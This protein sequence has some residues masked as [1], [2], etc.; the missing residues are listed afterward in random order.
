V[1]R[2][3]LQAC[4]P[5][6][7]SAGMVCQFPHGQ[8]GYPVPSS[9]ASGKI[10]EAFA[11]EVHRFAKASGIPV[12]HLAR[13]GK[14][15]EIARPYI[16]AA[17]AGGKGA[18]ARTG[19]AQEKAVVWRS[20]PARGQRGTA[21][22]HTERGRQTAFASHFYSCLRDAGRGP[23][24]RKASACAPYPVWI[25][26]NGHERARR[27]PARGGTGF[28]ALDN[29]FASCED[30]ALPRR[31]CDRLGPGA[32]TGF[33]WRW[34]HRLPSPFTRDDLRAGYAC[35]LAFRQFGV[36]GTRVLDRPA[37]GRAFFE[38]LIRDHPGPGRPGRVPLVFGRNI[39]LAGAHPAPGTFRTKVITRGVD[40]GITCCCR[41]SRIRQYFKGAPGA[42][43]RAGR[44]RHPRRRH[45]AAADL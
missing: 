8:R 12:R 24:F 26:L 41:S 43:H 25:C 35:E 17:A 11:A 13:G 44:L 14:K 38:G 45:R 33:F 37:A 7:Q 10:G 20:W 9:A 30:P 5:R 28:A 1:D 16:R 39:R 19:I 27:Q 21:H 40:P 42:A 22:P 34:L 18:V 29:G 4:V 3:F 6:L 15:E 2:I 31:V 36:S 32:V 23:A